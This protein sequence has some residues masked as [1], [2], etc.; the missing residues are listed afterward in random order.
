[1]LGFGN[2]DRPNVI[3]NPTLDNPTADRWFNTAAFAVPTR[4]TF[5]NAG[6]NI[7]DG[8][9]LQTF[10]LSLVKNTVFSDRYTLQFRSE[11]FNAFDRANFG[12][13]DNFVGNPAFGRILS[14]GDPRRIQLGLKLLF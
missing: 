14:A 2:N 5:G 4:G 8:P 7:L 10:N 1:V 11:F 12:L 13:P 9:G 3:A 6:R